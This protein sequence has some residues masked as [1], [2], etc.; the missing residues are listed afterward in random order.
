MRYVFAGA[1]AALLVAIGSGQAAATG[2]RAPIRFLGIGELGGTPLLGSAPGGGELLRFSPK[3]HVGLGAILQN[4]SG[5]RLVITGARVLVP[6]HTLMHQI[7]TRFHP[8][9]PRT[10][11]SRASCP[12]QSF[13]IDTHPYRMEPKP[14]T[15]RPGRDVGIELDFVLG[16]CAEIRGANPAPLTRLR[17]TFRRPDGSIGDRIVSLEGASSIQLRTPKPG[18]CAQPRSSLSV[19]GP[20]KWSTSELWTIPGST[21]DVCTIRHGSLDFTSREYQIHIWKDYSYKHWERVALHVDHFRGLGAYQGV[22]SVT[23][24]GG[25]VWLQRS[26]RN[27]EV[28]M[29]TPREIFALIQAGRQPKGAVRGMVR[30]RIAG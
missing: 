16:S 12:G 1:L 21:G 19:N 9:K 18:D 3:A 20:Q 26:T 11:P 15:V 22:V 29:S 28:K 13:P 14:F 6:P 7:G 24:A 8:W 5:M 2:S 23:T 4:R 30:C 27:I 17:V 25:R 10:C